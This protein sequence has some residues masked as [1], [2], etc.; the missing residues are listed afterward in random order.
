[1]E[2]K[3]VLL[4]GERIEAVLDAPV[5]LQDGV[6]AIDGSGLTLMPGLIDTHV[7]FADWMAPVFL[8]FGVTTVRDVGNTVGMILD[9]RQRERRGALVGPRIVAHGALL[10]GAPPPGGQVVMP[11][12][13]IPV[14][15]AANGRTVAEHQIEHD[16]DG[17]KV[18]AR[19]PLESMRGVVEVAKAHGLPVAAHVGVVSAREAVDAGVTSIEHVYGVATRES[20]ESHEELAAYMAGRGTFVS[21]TLHMQTV[22]IESARLVAEFPYLDLV[23]RRLAADWVAGGF[24]PGSWFPWPAERVAVWQREVAQRGAFVRR[25]HE[26]G[27]RVTTGTDTSAIPYVL[28]GF[29]VHQ[30]MER[31]VE[32]GLSAADAV[33]AATSVAAELVRRSDL[34]VIAAGKLADLM[35]VEGDPTVNVSAVRNVRLVMKGGVVVHRAE[36]IG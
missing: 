23:P 20:P 18:Y 28:P 5:E 4:S 8:R 12:S 35:L 33:R 3:T 15:D 2:G 22:P 27:G 21:A 25:F 9:A 16:L 10:D 14:G 17:L 32:F 26:A 30:E 6:A 1:V 24:V 36:G 7:H 11:P 29:S 13:I 19:L 34:G 31:L